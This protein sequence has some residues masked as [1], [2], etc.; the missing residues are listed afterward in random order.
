MCCTDG[1]DRRAAPSQNCSA[2]PLH[3]QQVDLLLLLKDQVHHLPGLAGT[4]RPAPD[5]SLRVVLMQR[6]AI[7][8]CQLE[9][10][11]ASA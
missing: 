7:P 10:S 11:N 4:E 1:V 6:P 8:R 2:P 5:C 9:D 3:E